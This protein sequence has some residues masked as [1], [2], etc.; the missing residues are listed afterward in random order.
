MRRQLNLNL[1]TF[2]ATA[3]CPARR[4][5]EPSARGEPSLNSMLA[6]PSSGEVMVNLVFAFI[7]RG[8]APTRPGGVAFQFSSSTSTGVA[9]GIISSFQSWLM[10]GWTVRTARQIA[11]RAQNPPNRVAGGG[12][13]DDRGRP[14]PGGR[15]HRRGGRGSPG[16]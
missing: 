7:L 10:L 16:S 12:L 6:T 8:R 11:G 4:V 9:I 5:L 1:P 3:V 14:G 15:S 2:A 13:S